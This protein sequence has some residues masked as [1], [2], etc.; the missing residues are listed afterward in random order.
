MIKRI[1]AVICVTLF[2]AGLLPA[3]EHSARAESEPAETVTAADNSYSR[4]LASFGENA[5]YPQLEQEISIEAGDS[6]TQGSSSQIIESFHE[7]S[8]VLLIESGRQSVTWTVDAPQ[9]GFYEIAASHFPVSAGLGK[10][11]FSLSVNGTVPFTQANHLILYNSHRMKS[12]EPVLDEH[13]NQ[14]A[15]DSEVNPA[16]TRQSL[17]NPDQNSD[18][19]LLFYLEQ[20]Q[21]ELIFTFNENGAFALGRL[22]LQSVQAPPPYTEYVNSLG[23]VTTG[24][25]GIVYTEA[26]KF[27]LASDTTLTPAAN[28]TDPVM[29]PYSVSRLTLNC[30]DGTWAESGQ[31]LEWNVEAPATGW[32][33]MSFRYKQEEL[34]SICAR[35]RLT[36]DGT[37]PF[38]EANHIKFP[39]SSGWS[40]FTFADDKEQPYRLYLE[41]GQT[42]ALRLEVVLGELE[43]ILT[44]M[45]QLIYDLNA[46]YRKIIMIT[47]TNP[48]QYRDYNLD[49]ELPGMINDLK[50]HAASVIACKDTFVA[51][52]G[53]STTDCTALLT[54]QR[55]LI[56][57]IKEP[58]TIP[59]RMNNLQSNIGSVSAWISSVSRQ[60]LSLDYYTLWQTEAAPKKSRANWFDSALHAVRSFIS[61]FGSSYTGFGTSAS[62]KTVTLWYGGGREQ[63]EIL[64]K[65]TKDQFTPQYD[66]NVN[67][68]LVNASIVEA[69]LSGQPPDLAINVGR[70]I[71]V[72]L[73]VRSALWDLS[74]FEDFA[75]TKAWF[76]PTALVPYTYQNSVY[77]LPDSQ[78]FNMLF[79]RK[80]ILSDLNIP[81]PQTWEEFTQAAN[82]LH[83]YNL[84]TGIPT[85]GDASVYYS[86]LLQKKGSVFNEQLSRTMLEAPL[87]VSAFSEWTDFYNKTGL[88]LS[89]SFF[90]RFR[91]GEMPLAVAPYTMYG[92][93][94]TAAP[95]IRGLWD[96]AL[97]PGTADEQGEI[98]RTVCAGGS[99]AVLLNTSKYPGEAW[100]FIK[101]WASEQAQSDFARG[102]ESKMG[103]IARVAVANTAALQSQ[104]WRSD[105]LSLIKQQ[106]ECIQEVPQIPGQYYLDRDLI[107]AFRDVVYN[108]RN[109]HETILEYGSRINGEIARKR[110]EFG[111]E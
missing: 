103:V 83:L 54:L 39:Y 38:A 62:R 1:T 44:E 23:G 29:S 53:G 72:N 4:Y 26:E 63:S 79:Y 82:Q 108:K 104:S 41:E 88:P 27:S 31:W 8:N 59:Y 19:A 64:W 78:V 89:Y 95:E 42:Y 110:E 32:Y 22:M 71:P 13:Q 84:E 99:A 6:L 66:V 2:L 94:E 91:S 109:P 20:G 56:S 34:K 51:A 74:S 40:L 15:P 7:L 57:F 16:W 9:A 14:F 65:L 81:L 98:N 10:I 3:Y 60:P 37:V 35:R 76:S 86:M 25:K 96:M 80:D 69:F 18:D 30:I 68:K 17:R 36:V 87:S 106:Q 77:A 105:T 58:E 61:S 46:L 24:G 48:D 12:S 43:P 21:N 5:S 85:E 33:Q 73:A 97:V 93:L 50:R 47:T 70:D 92:Q 11:M 28:R 52:A 75:E 49:A 102:V 100:Q 111:L 101:W 90:N 45:N 107:N 55:Q 67:I